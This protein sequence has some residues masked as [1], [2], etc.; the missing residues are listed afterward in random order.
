MEDTT[1]ISFDANL[2]NRAFQRVAQTALLP[3]GPFEILRLLP[4]P[5]NSKPLSAELPIVLVLV[6]SRLLGHISGCKHTETDLETRLQQFQSDLVNEGYQARCVEVSMRKNPMHRDGLGVLA[7]RS[8]F[9][10]FYADHPTFK[11]AILIGSFPEA[12][13]VRRWV[14]KKEQLKTAYLAGK[15]YHQVNILEIPPEIIAE[16]ADIVLADLTGHWDQVYQPGPMEIDW[17]RAKPDS[18]Q[19]P[20]DGDLFIS[21]AFEITKV[22]YEDFFYIHDDDFARLS[23]PEELL[24][25]RWSKSRNPEL[26]AA[27]ALNPNP[28][29][30]PDIMV[31]RINARNIA[32][33]P[34]K[35]FKDKDG[36]G[37][38]DSQ[39]KPQSVETTFPVFWLTDSGIWKPDPALERALLIDYF[40]RNHRFRSG[41]YS[42]LP[43]RVAA[44]ASSDFNAP[45]M[46]YYLGLAHPD[47]EAPVV[48]DNAT[49]LDFVQW[50]K[51]P[52]LLKGI[53]AHGT[54]NSTK[55]DPGSFDA[56]ALEAAAGGHPWHWTT[57]VV[58]ASTIKPSFEAQFQGDI[59]LYRTMRENDILSNT[60]PSIYIHTGCQVN[61]PAM[62]D[63]QPYDNPSY[64]T[65]QEAESMMFYL[66]GLAVVA[67]AKVFYDWPK[68]FT[69]RIAEPNTCLGDGLAAYFDAEC[70]DG[71]I[72][73][74]DR[75]RAYWW[76]M[77]GDFTL[78]LAPGHKPIR[79]HKP[80]ARV[81]PLPRDRWLI[82]DGV[83]PIQ[84]L[85]NKASADLVARIICEC[86]LHE[87]FVVGY[88]EPIWEYYLIDGEYSG[89]QAL[90]EPRLNLNP[91]ALEVRL[92]K[93]K[94]EAMAGDK[95]IAS[96]AKKLDLELIVSIL[97][98]HSIRTISYLG[99]LDH[100]DLVF[101]GK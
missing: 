44:I 86:G 17:I 76:S 13:L 40:D 75:K 49:L 83:E 96:S 60:G 82:T 55:F 41:A 2:Y 8:L 20:P 23:S 63:S 4:Y 73:E 48:K 61:S 29:A 97:R 7:L 89:K 25:V 45:D 90:G 22:T 30:R 65:F 53:S 11:G 46:A 39:G 68:D 26:S 18:G 88:P 69:A 35:A 87:R 34:D 59:H 27:D 50:L 52:A 43:F 91:A 100:P 92:G 10:A 42:G 9:Q 3:N 5:A 62:A 99:S 67:R 77:L 98:E 16:R 79:F 32:V 64:A 15:E 33:S 21:S 70:M 81:L 14:W 58:L 19:F 6:E 94:W 85:A 101:L 12:M 51:Q 28:I 84:I 31:S 36:K 71:K 95:I 57:E 38:L 56:A 37:F 93:E 54:A 72:S 78:R 80:E 74:T 66:N 24:M 1:T 47:F